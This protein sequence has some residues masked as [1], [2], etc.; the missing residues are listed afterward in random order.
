MRKLDGQNPLT[1]IQAAVDLYDA[2]LVALNEEPGC[3]VVIVCRT[4]DLPEQ[5][6]TNG[7]PDKPWQ[8]PKLEL[9]GADLRALLKARSLKTSSP[10]QIIRRDTWDPSCK[11]RDREQRRG[12]QDDATKAWNLHTALYYKAGGV[13]GGC[14]GRP[15]T[16]RAASSVWRSTALRAATGSRPASLKCSTNEATESLFGVRQRSSQEPIAN[17]TSAR[18]TPRIYL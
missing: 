17:R 1:A 3:D 6:M 5:V 15:R 8:D 13:R 12:Q 4:D 7:N 10:I 14:R 18:P 16:S 9:V 11:P 2:E